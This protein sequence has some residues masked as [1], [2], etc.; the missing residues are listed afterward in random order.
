MVP[1]I[2]VEDC[3]SLNPFHAGLNTK[4][5]DSGQLNLNRKPFNF[6]EI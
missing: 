6:L 2:M 5:L 1:K 3:I 4:P